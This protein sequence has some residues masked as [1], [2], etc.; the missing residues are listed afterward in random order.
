MGKEVVKSVKEG[1]VKGL[2]EPRKG[3][4]SHAFPSSPSSQR[5]H[6]GQFSLPSGSLAQSHPADV[7]PLLF[8]ICLSEAKPMKHPCGISWETFPCQGDIAVRKIAIRPWGKFHR[9]VE[10]L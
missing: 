8:W 2:V 9:G 7:L 1:G 6:R 10:E 3:P 4:L 5:I